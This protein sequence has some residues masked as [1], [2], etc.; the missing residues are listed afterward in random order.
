[1]QVPQWAASVEAAER[2]LRLLENHQA[3]LRAEL[4]RLGPEHGRELKD[5]LGL[6]AGAISKVSRALRA[7]ETA[8]PTLRSYAFGRRERAYWR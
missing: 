6:T 2:Q 7:L 8:Q 3:R 5:K 1:M 4:A